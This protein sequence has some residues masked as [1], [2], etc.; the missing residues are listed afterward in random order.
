MGSDQYFI[1]FMK[2]DDGSKIHCRSDFPVSKGDTVIVRTGSGEKI[3]KVI[4]TSLYPKS[5]NVYS[6]WGENSIISFSKEK[7]DEL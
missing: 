6:A 7:N 5:G 1:A 3:G 4:S 2:L